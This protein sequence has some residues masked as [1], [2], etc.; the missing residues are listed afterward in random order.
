MTKVNILEKMASK[1]SDIPPMP[2]IAV[3]LM[4]MI[5][6]P[7]VSA[8][9][10]KSLISNDQGITARLL[11]V[12]NSAYY[13]CARK[14]STLTHAIVILGFDT[15]F[16][17]VLVNSLL[18]IYHTQGK[19]S[20]L[21]EKL[22]FEHSVGCAMA[23]RFLA[24]QIPIL[25]IESSFI[26]GLLHDIGKAVIN[27]NYPDKFEEILRIVYNE[28]SS[29]QKV[30]KAILGFDHA[31]LGEVI[32]DKWKFSPEIVTSVRYH[33]EPASFEGDPV[34]PN[35]ANLGDALCISL[36]IGRREANDV[37]KL[38][39]QAGNGLLGWD[40]EKWNSVK[41]SFSLIY[42][43]NISAFSK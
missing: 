37:L 24:Q 20:G 21:K 5:N 41:E 8:H 32:L 25:Q 15:I 12:A 33:H 39:Y 22:M 30:E 27:M 1:I 14:I 28:G 11:K 10:L 17:I 7:K 3:Q 19:K 18:S 40:E 31:E 9:D 42:D 2:H 16:N 38:Q 35:I 36:G 43:E 23:C 13:G 29:F 4:E 34:L 6:D 26:C